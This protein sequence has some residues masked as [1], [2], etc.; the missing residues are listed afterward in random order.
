MM[1][2]IGK[3]SL[4]LSASFYLIWFIPQIL[5]NFKRKNTEGF[6]IIMHGILGIAYL[7]DLIYG[8]GLNMP[9]QYRSVT[10]VG[11]CSLI[12]QHYQLHRYG[13]H[14]IKERTIFKSLNWI[15]LLLFCY[16]IY[17]ITSSITTRNSYDHIGML[18]NIC[19][20]CYMFPQIIKNY[21]NQSVQGLSVAFVLIAMFLNFCDAT[22]AWALAWDYPSKIGPVISFFGN[23]ILLFQVFY[24]DKYSRFSHVVIDR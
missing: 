7:S 3:L 8:F 1:N 20:L 17:A 15:Y 2:F 19:F 11:L 24:Y 21:R 16:G 23:F 10:I 13:L 14:H 4:N 22:S 5:L 6:S 12:L 9:W 18:A